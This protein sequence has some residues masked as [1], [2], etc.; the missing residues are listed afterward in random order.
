M[1][2]KRFFAAALAAVLLIL[3]GAAAFVAW[4][5][6]IHVNRKM[7]PGDTAL[8]VNQRYEMPGLIRNQDYSAVVMG[9]SLVANYRASWFTE[10]LGVETLKITF[11]DGWISE[12]DTALELAFD[13][14]PDLKQVYFCFDPNILIRSD[15]ARTVELPQYLY[16]TNPFDDVEF[17]LNADSVILAAKT[18]KARSENEGTDLDSAYIWDNNYRFDREQAIA[19]YPRPEESGVILPADAYYD[20]CEENLAV[21]TRWLEEHPDVQFTIWFPPYSILYWDKMDREGSTE[22]VISAVELAAERLL[23]YDN[24]SLHCFLFS[25]QT[26]CGLEGYT[27]HIHCDGETTHWIANEILAGRWHLTEENYQLRLDELREFVANY[28]YDGNLFPEG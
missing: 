12:F 16:N 28:D 10:A 2:A 19:S 11:P 9:T 20:A 26:V 27:D 4:V 3:G 24:V 17:Y 22:A 14:H 1:N 7:E 8:F 6:P 15:A 23:Q 21:V 5:D 18:L 25:Y 13:T